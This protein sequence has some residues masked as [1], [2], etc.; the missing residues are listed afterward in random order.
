MSNQNILS[1]QMLALLICEQ[2]NHYYQAD[3]VRIV[4]K[5]KIKKN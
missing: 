4:I 1:L 5:V 2:S 3:K